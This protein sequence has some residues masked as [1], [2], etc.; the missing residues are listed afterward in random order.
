MCLEERGAG[1]LK[2]GTFGC[3]RAAKRD[4]GGGGLGVTVCGENTAVLRLRWVSTSTPRIHILK[5]FADKA[6]VGFLN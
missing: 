1:S 2:D 5:S 6:V 4:G 3:E